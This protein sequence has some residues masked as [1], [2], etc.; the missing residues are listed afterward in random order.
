MNKRERHFIAV[1]LLCLPL[2]GWG[3]MPREWMAE[4]LL[5][6]KAARFLKAAEAF[7]EAAV[8]A[9]NT[10]LDPAYAQYNLGAALYRK[11]LVEKA[12]E[13]FE[14]ALETTD[15]AV[16]IPAWFNLGNARMAV[17]RKQAGREELESALNSMEGAM[18]AYVS[19]MMLDPDDPA[20]KVN[21]ELAAKKAE[22]LK[23][24]IRKKNH[25]YSK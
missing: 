4:G 7:Q 19:A 9:E 18:D 24:E 13:R 6:F 15:H 22:W 14:A 5:E 17:G 20:P 16:Q 1:A 2:A 3:G 11:G 21:F 8:Q 23:E 12:V 25:T 10:K